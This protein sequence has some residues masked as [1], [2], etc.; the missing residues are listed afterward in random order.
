MNPTIGRYENGLKRPKMLFWIVFLLCLT[1]TTL[2]ADQQRSRRIL[3]KEYREYLRAQDGQSRVMEAAANRRVVL[4]A[5]RSAL[6]EEPGSDSPEGLIYGRIDQIKTRLKPDEMTIAT[7]VKKGGELSL[8]YSLTFI[9]PGYCD[10]LNAVAYLRHSTTLF[11]PVN[12]L[13][14]SQVEQNGRGGISFIIKGTVVLPEGSK[15]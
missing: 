12:S 10:L 4:T 6:P 8:Q 5:L 9:D 11:T 7:L 1:V 13:A 15:P 3:E 14:V 2:W